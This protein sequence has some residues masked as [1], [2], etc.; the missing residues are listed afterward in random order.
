MTAWQ[1]QGVA[2]VGLTFLMSL[3]YAGATVSSLDG[4]WPWWCTA[5]FAAGTVVSVGL[6]AAVIY[7]LWSER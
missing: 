3:V 4:T 6:L 2:L 5:F 1:W 7:G